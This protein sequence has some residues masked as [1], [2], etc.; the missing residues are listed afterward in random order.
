MRKIGYKTLVRN[1]L[2]EEVTQ[3][4][5]DNLEN[6]RADF[7]SALRYDST[8]TKHSYDMR[9]YGAFINATSD[10][11][12][13][14]YPYRLL[15]AG[16]Y[17]NPFSQ[18]EYNKKVYNKKYNIRNSNSYI[19][20][21][22]FQE[23]EPFD[24]QNPKYQTRSPNTNGYGITFLIVHKFSFYVGTSGSAS[25]ESKSTCYYSVMINTADQRDNIFN[26]HPI[27]KQFRT[28]GYKHIPSEQLYNQ[29]ANIVDSMIDE[30]TKQF[31]PPQVKTSPKW[32]NQNN[33]NNST[34]SNRD[35][36]LIEKVYKQYTI[37][38]EQDIQNLTEDGKIPSDYGMWG[39]NYNHI[40]KTGTK[41]KTIFLTPVALLGDNISYRSIPTVINKSITTINSY[42][43]DEYNIS[44]MEDDTTY[45]L[46]VLKH[47]FYQVANGDVSKE[48][49]IEEGNS[50]NKIDANN[51]TIYIPSE[52][53]T[54]PSMETISENLRVRPVE[55]LSPLAI[56]TLSDEIN[57][58]SD[59]ETIPNKTISSKD[60]L[61]EVFGNGSQFSKA[62]I[63]FPKSGEKL[64][65][66][67][68]FV[69]TSNGSYRQ[70]KIST[71]GGKDG[72]GAAHSIKGL[73]DVIASE[74]APILYGDTPEHEIEE[75]MNEYLSSHLGIEIFNEYKGELAILMM[76]VTSQ[77][78]DDQ[79]E[80]LEQ[81]CSR[82]KIFNLQLPRSQG[83]IP[84]IPA[85]IKFMSN[86]HRF[87]D[88]IMHLLNIQKYDFAQ[89]NVKPN[90]TSKSIRF[91]YTIQYPAIFKGHIKFFPPK[92]GK[93]SASVKMH[94]VGD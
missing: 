60:I 2:L 21:S 26:N 75:Y 72:K 43:R 64:A 1:M 86:H 30:V 80:I 76:L 41:T 90:V 54:E 51:T 35:K 40:K 87:S 27:L 28:Q 74:K 45:S 14:Y 6:L 94:I 56:T 7:L 59:S 70:L 24:P 91:D 44:K 81:L 93:S 55:V 11:L 16:L 37:L 34:I 25:T 29:V 78:V 53:Y 82:T 68:I 50:S 4:D 42:L 36:S 52:H 67:S 46:E 84:S 9:S 77:G 48:T 13:V 10:M 63:S 19:P 31:N 22:D 92:T 49:T 79:V 88:I 8:P 58:G 71:K 5:I 15:E 17:N 69:P 18:E 33:D 38:E 12:E 65:D 32:A 61:M 62:I 20:V 66:S 85:F 83:S 23:L 73:L 39:K 57:W 47:K 3:Q 89:V